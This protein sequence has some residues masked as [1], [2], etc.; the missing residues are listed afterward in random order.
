MFQKPHSG[1]TNKQTNKNLTLAA[2][3]NGF[4]G[5]KLDRGQKTTTEAILTVK[6]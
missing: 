4:D 3:E 5:I 2:V 6:S 1:K